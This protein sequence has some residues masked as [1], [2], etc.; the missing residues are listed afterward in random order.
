MTRRLI[1]C[2]LLVFVTTLTACA[3][4]QDAAPAPK[5]SPPSPTSF[6]ATPQHPVQ[7]TA[8][9]PVAAPSVRRC[10]ASVLKG[11]VEP[12]DATAGA[13]Y[14]KFIVT[15]TG[16]APCTLNGYSGFELQNSAGVALPTKLERKPEPGPA[17]VSLAPGARAAEN[18][19]WGVVPLGNEPAVG[20][21]EPAPAQ[22]AA[23][24]PDETAALVVQWSLGPVC[25]GGRIEISAFYAV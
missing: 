13:R 18:M 5:P 24:P 9:A 12:G 4:K 21:C 23:I 7:T 22:A 16:T 17:A 3:Q 8:A 14:G 15:N 2:G 10:D 1:A 11:S 19:R 6:S 25:A 20:P